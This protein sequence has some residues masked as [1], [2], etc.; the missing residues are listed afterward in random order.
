MAC[1]LAP[2][3]GLPRQATRLAGSYRAAAGEEEMGPVPE[4]L[5]P[6]ASPSSPARLVQHTKSALAGD[7]S[8]YALG[9]GPHRPDLWPRLRPNAHSRACETGVEVIVRGKEQGENILRDRC[10]ERTLR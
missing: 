1:S 10:Q 6:K 7:P 4:A 2:P 8:K 9:L 3:R 5:R